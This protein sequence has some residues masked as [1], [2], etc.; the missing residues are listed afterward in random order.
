[1]KLIAILITCGAIFCAEKTLSYNIEGMT[2]S[3]GC[4]NKVNTAITSIEG[5]SKCNVDFDNKMAVVTYDTE[6][7]KSTD[8]L[9]TIHEGTEFKASIISTDLKKE[10]KVE[11]KT[12]FQKIFGIFGA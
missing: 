12:L 6:K 9:A 1:M 2:C 10:K 3:F 7:V 11:K 8:I 5:V 4:A